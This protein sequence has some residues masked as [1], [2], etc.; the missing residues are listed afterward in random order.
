MSS[1]TSPKTVLYH[2][3]ITP[4]SFLVLAVGVAGVVALWT[5]REFVLLIFLA[6]IFA[7]F[8]NSGARLLKHAHI[9]RTF[10]VVLMYLFFAGIIS[11]L[12]L[13]FFP[14][15]FRELSGFI[16]YLPKSSPW[17][18]LLN[19]I[20]DQ[21]FTGS[22]FKSI[23]GTSN[24]IQGIQN[25]WKIYLTDPVLAGISS[26]FKNLAN[27]FLVFIMSFFL[28]IKEGALNSFLRMITPIKH[29]SYVVD[30]WNRVEKK[31]G[32]WFGGQ[33]IIALITGVV[34]FIGLSLLGMPYA[35]ILSILIIILEFIPFGMVF[36]TIV[37]IPLAFFSGG[38]A[39]GLPVALF[40]SSLNFIES[41][42]LQP[43]I[44]NKT[45]GVPMLLVIISIV[46]WIELIGWVG[47]F[48]AI[49]FAVLILEIVYDR[50]KKAILESPET[51]SIFT[52]ETSLE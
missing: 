44:V 26:I 30:L 37:I 10:G 2:V 27:V 35:L 45:V 41:K 25:F 51:I 6:I 52:E 38:I 21:G 14:L 22:T 42:V 12:V 17:T 31:I 13:V 5:V 4:Q 33:L 15:L 36:G 50:E 40:I 24:L 46:A 20:S 1:E 29:E 8:V 48:V 18:K 7:S 28:S 43:V 16:D 9:P 47:A 49:P 11:L 23:V 39:L 32:Y 19:T 3:D 34:S